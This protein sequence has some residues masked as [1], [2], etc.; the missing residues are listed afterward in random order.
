MPKRPHESNLEYRR[1]VLDP[2]S[3]TFCAAKWYNATIWLGSGSTASCHHPPAHKIPLELIE[4]QPQ[5]LHNT[6]WKK[7][8]RKSMHQGERP[9][10]CEY[11]WKVE[12]LKTD[13]VSDRVFKSIIYSDEEIITAS[14]L[15]AESDVNPIN[16]EIAF[17]RTC[18]FACI[19]CNANFSTTWGKDIDKS[20]PYENLEHSDGNAYRIDGRAAQPWSEEEN[21]YVQAFWKWWPD[22]K[23]SLRELRITGGEPLMAQSVWKLFDLYGKGDCDEVAL[24]I[25]SNLGGRDE[26]ID[27]LIEKS[28]NVPEFHLYTSCETIGAQAEYIR[29][30]LN[31]EKWK[32]NVEKVCQKAKL[33][34]L[35]V[36]MTINALSL[37]GMVDFLNQMQEWKVQYGRFFPVWTVNILRFPA[38]L[39]CAT[40]PPQLRDG[41]KR[42][43]E[44]WLVEHKD[45]ELVH[46]IERDSLLRLIHYLDEVK[47]PHSRAPKQTMNQRDL[48]TFLQQYDVRREKSRQETFPPELNNW[49]DSIS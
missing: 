2:I 29:D 17:D 8:Q 20:G 30:G 33:S 36:M 45:D 23:K 47:S 39:S 4:Q 6:P 13:N 27:R 5:A 16:L 25:N 31:Y 43:L 7:L 21:P 10:E 48:K 28:H 19:Y 11:C 41:I 37:F 34:S 42:D 46:E 18:Q 1:R 40:L 9:E 24:S 22:L 49:L 3:P 15:N 44:L 35:N 32:I 12:D 26:L 38:F 14:S